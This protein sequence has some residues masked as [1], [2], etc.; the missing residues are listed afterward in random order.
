MLGIEFSVQPVVISV[1]VLTHFSPSFSATNFTQK[2]VLVHDSQNCLWIL[3]DAFTIQPEL[4]STVAVC[5]FTRFLLCTNLFCKFK[6]FRRVVQMFDVLIV[7]TSGNLKN[8]AQVFYCIPC[9]VPMNDCI[10]E[11]WL[12]FLSMDRI[13]SR[14]SSFSIFNRLISYACSATMS[15]GWASF[16][17]L[18]FGRGLIPA[19]SFRCCRLNR[20]TQFLMHSLSTPNFCA[21]SRFVLP[22]RF[23]SKISF[24]CSSI[25]TYFLDIAKPPRVVLLSYTGRLF[26]YC[27]LFTDLFTRL[28]E[29]V[30]FR[31]RHPF[32]ATCRGQGGRGRAGRGCRAHSTWNPTRPPARTGAQRRRPASAGCPTC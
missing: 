16:R 13:K 7:T 15:L 19:V 29:R 25:F 11:T 31:L 23:S 18:P 5:L 22:S 12:H 1:L 27:L 10:F 21:I 3:S 24:P 4:H 8:F 2:V 9:T 30:F 14:S 6:V 32:P 28:T 17:G 26:V 20:V